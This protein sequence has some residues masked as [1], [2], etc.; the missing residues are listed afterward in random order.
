[1]AQNSLSVISVTD[2]QLQKNN[3]LYDLMAQ[4][5]QWK[6][7]QSTQSDSVKTENSMAK[8]NVGKCAQCGTENM[9]LKN[10]FDKQVCS[11]CSGMRSYVRNF[12]ESV[13]KALQEFHGDA[14]FPKSETSNEHVLENVPEQVLPLEACISS[15]DEESA[16]LDMAL[17]VI[18]GD[19]Q[20][21]ADQLELLRSK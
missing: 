13:V 3:R 15:T 7:K 16:L 19:G 8:S 21:I 5:K 4:Y 20:V 14:Y 11:R 18:R 12:P 10:H 9:R 17:A 1:M 2:E 6:D